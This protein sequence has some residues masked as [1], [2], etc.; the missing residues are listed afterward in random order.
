[1]KAILPAVCLALLT[2]SLACPA[3][4]GD[5]PQTS[6]PPGVETAPASDPGTAPAVAPLPATPAPAPA[7]PPTAVPD[8]PPV[9]AP[10]PAPA[11]DTLVVRAAEAENVTDPM[12]AVEGGGDDVNPLIFIDDVPLTD[13]IRSLA[14]QSE[15]NFMFDPQITSSNQPNI[16][17]RFENVT[18]QEALMAVLD[19][20]N[21]SL[22]R[23]PRSKIARI[24]IKDPKAEEPLVTKI[25]QLKY[26]DPTNLVEVIKPTLSPR[27]RVLADARTRQ[28]IV[29]TTEKEVDGMMT[30]IDKLDARTK[31]VLIEAR[32]FETLKNPHTIKGINWEGTFGAQKISM[33]NNS[34]YT[35][36]LEPK[37]P[38]GSDPGYGGALSGLLPGVPRVLANAT[39][40]PFFNPAYAFINA[41]GVS[42]VVSFLNNQTDTELLATPR[43]VTLDNQTAN[44]SV[45]R[46][47]PVFQI[48]PG[49]ANSP[50][51]ATITYT[52]LGTILKV[53]PRIAADNNISLT[54][55][56]EVSNID[57]KDEQTINGELNVANIYSFRRIETQVM[58]PSGYT[59][60]MGGLIDDRSSKVYSKVPILGDIPI[61]GFAFRHSEKGR[62]K[63]NMMVFVTPTIV[64]ENDFQVAETSSEFLRTQL[65]EREDVEPNAWDSAK[66][67]DWTKP[68]E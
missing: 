3:Q 22:V 65:T 1:M 47:Y 15:I 42:A 39:G 21:L 48:T 12:P 36:G 28:L 46:A 26:S 32:I 17:I 19:N 4:T 16:S 5:T 68:V 6:P 57:G 18:A 23:Q 61:L 7:D 2:G 58:I 53:T 59:L 63:K 54:V 9:P 41:D 44:L 8:A 56:P 33:G 38:T 67:H 51:G 25:I 60:V 35:S 13:A 11:T 30:L 31:Q 52:N 43:A 40:G 14:R 34:A 62:E 37:P 64:H 45:T 49:S 66:P 29:N 27:S 50:A 24:C 10:T 55:I 20:H